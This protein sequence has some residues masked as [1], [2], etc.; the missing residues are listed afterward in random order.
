MSFVVDGNLS[1]P[2]PREIH[3]ETQCAPEGLLTGVDSK[4]EF[5]EIARPASE[6]LLTGVAPTREIHLENQC[7]SEVPVEGVTLRGG[8]KFVPP[9]TAT[10][11]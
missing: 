6:A 5:H 4:G 3:L 1:V 11:L 2:L 9:Q 7:T 10:C 8:H